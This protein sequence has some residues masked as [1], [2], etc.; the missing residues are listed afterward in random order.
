M[1][2]LI[3]SV[4][5]LLV[6]AVAGGFLI[7][8][9]PTWKQHVI[10]VIN[11]A[12]KE[13]RILGEMKTNLD[14]LNKTTSDPKAKNLISKSQDLL[15]NITDI[16]QNNSGIIKQGVSKIID[17]LIDH[18]PYPADHLTTAENTSPAPICSPVK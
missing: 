10:E 2:F 17:A 11:P 9:V 18:T 4:L 15:Q 5:I 7:N 6:I 3:K 13:A 12:A 1:G 14:E 8:G 16:N